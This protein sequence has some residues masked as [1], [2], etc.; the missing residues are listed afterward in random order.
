M[1][2]WAK[3]WLFV[4]VV[5]ALEIGLTELL[6]II[7]TGWHA[8]YTLSDTI[9]RWSEVHRWVAPLTIGGGA[10]LLAHFFLI[11]NKRS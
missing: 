11:S 3:I 6:A 7:A 8:G 2:R 5:V 10:F 9:R 4:L 1:R